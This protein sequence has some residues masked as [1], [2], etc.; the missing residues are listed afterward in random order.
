MILAVN[1]ENVVGKTKAEIAKLVSSAELPLMMKIGA[2]DDSLDVSCFHYDI[3]PVMHDLFDWDMIKQ[4]SECTIKPRIVDDDCCQILV[5][6][7][8]ANVVKCVNLLKREAEK[9]EVVD[10]DGIAFILHH[11]DCRILNRLK[12]DCNI[13]ST[14]INDLKYAKS[15]RIAIRGNF[16][17]RH[18]FKSYL[19]NI[20]MNM[21][22]VVANVPITRNI[23]TN[24]QN[25]MGAIISVHERDPQMAYIHDG[26]FH[27]GT[28]MRVRRLCVELKKT[29]TFKQF[30]QQ[31]EVILG[32]EDQK[33]DLI[34]NIW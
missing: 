22:E 23:I 6:G 32:D 30:M 33:T 29:P 5:G 21:L 7:C 2:A 26:L 27:P 1:G 18:K 34:Q 31:H 10:I 12:D 16:V 17:D 13:V 25:E 24:L 8:K 20:R 11:A 9:I 19:D 15:S 3:N 28:K 14:D 4:Q